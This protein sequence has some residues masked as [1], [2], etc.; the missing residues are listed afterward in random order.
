[1][2]TSARTTGLMARFYPSRLSFP[3]LGG[4]GSVPNPIAG[5]NAAA[6]EWPAL[7]QFECDRAGHAV[8][9]RDAAAKQQWM[10]VQADPVDHARFEQ[11]PPQFTA[12]HDEDVL[13]GLLLQAP[14]EV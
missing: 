11:R 3:P 13:P 10:D 14:D 2:A 4:R 5:V 7:F 1:M 12:A 9:Q 8:E 6:R